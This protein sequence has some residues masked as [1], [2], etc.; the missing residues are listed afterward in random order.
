M[1]P[2]MCRHVLMGWTRCGGKLSRTRRR[3]QKRSEGGWGGGSAVMHLLRLTTTTP[4]PN[5]SPQGGGEPTEYA[6]TTRIKQK[7]ART[8]SML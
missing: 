5:P 1:T 7:R 2:M 6:A 3:P 4:I 8:N